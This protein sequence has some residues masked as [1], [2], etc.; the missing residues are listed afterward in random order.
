[1]AYFTLC[2]FCSCIFLSTHLGCFL[3]NIHRNWREI[4]QDKHS[5]SSSNNKSGHTKGKKRGGNL[6]LFGSKKTKNNM[7][8][9]F[10]KNVYSPTLEKKFK[11]LSKKLKIKLSKPTKKQLELRIVDC[12]KTFCNKSCKGY[13]SNNINGNFLKNTNSKIIEKLLSKGAISYCE[14][15]LFPN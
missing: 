12:K 8:N 14:K 3:N 11:K 1:M 9:N 4:V 2:L 6:K 15:N 5:Q 10:C 13:K 7:C